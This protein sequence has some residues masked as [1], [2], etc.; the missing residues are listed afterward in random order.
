MLVIRR[1]LILVFFISLGAAAQQKDSS[2]RKYDSL[3]TGQELSDSI[4]A[5][6]TDLQYHEGV[7]LNAKTYCTLLGSN[8][9]QQ[10]LFPLHAK[11]RDWVRA[12]VFTLA[13]VAVSFANRPI[14][15]FASNIYNHHP[16]VASASKY[17]TDFGGPYEVVTLGALYT[18]GLL[19]KSA[20]AKNTT[21]LAT[22]AYVIAGT[23]SGLGK[24]IFA[25]QR[26]YYTDIITQRTGPIFRGPFYA[27]KKGP[28]GEK[29][30]RSDYASFPSGHTTVAF[31]AATV[32]ALEYKDKPIIPIISYS[33][34][35]LIGLSRLTENK[36]WATDVIV[37]A[38]LGYLS[39]RQVVNNFHRYARLKKMR[40]NVD[41]VHFNLQ[42]HQNQ[43]VAGLVYKF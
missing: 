36:H 3:N 13:T 18:Y 11:R 35:T 38:M 37:G 25:E 40:G 23:I 26:P 27:F 9:K 42:Y 17:I 19:F 5:H 30:S 6:N 34:A 14:T 2:G 16:A 10:L 7:M 32:Y 21:M 39:G 1:F 12:G 33:A 20:K 43:F 28:N 8:F 4:P 31:A 24:F 29:L 22:Q 15:R 41:P